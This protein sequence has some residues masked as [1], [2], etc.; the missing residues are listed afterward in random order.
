MKTP[1]ANPLALW[2]TTA[3]AAG[4]AIAIAA[5]EEFS[6]R[7]DFPLMFVPFATSIVLVMGSP[8]IEAAQPRALIGG[9]LVASAVGLALVK[10]TGPGPF[11]A[12]F[13]VGLAMAAMQVTRSFHPPAGIDPL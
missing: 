8:E 12:A 5:M 13:A 2:L 3:G 10:I 11:A 6:S 9:H 1:F 4:G 7:A